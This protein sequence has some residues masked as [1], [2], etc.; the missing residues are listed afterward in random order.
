LREI[1]IE[2]LGIA[3]F[4]VLMITLI[5]IRLARGLT[6]GLN[7]LVTVA[8]N[9]EHGRPFQRQDI[10]REDEIGVLARHLY[11]M[12]D[13]IEAEKKAKIES[14]ARFR[15]LVQVV[16]IPLAYASKE[17]VIQYFN[18]RFVQVF[19]YRHEEIPTTK[20]WFDLVYPDEVYR[21]WVINNW[22]VAVQAAAASGQDIQPIEYTVTCKNGEVRI[23]EI[24]GVILGDELLATF[25][26]LTARKQAE[27]VLKE[28]EARFHAVFNNA[29][30]G[31][32]QV[33]T[34]GHFMQINQEFCKIIG[35]SKDEILSQGFTFQQITV[36]EDL[37]IDLLNINKLLQGFGSHYRVEKRYIRKNGSVVWVN[38]S[39]YLQR[40]SSSK[41]LYL[42]SAV[43]DISER[44]RAEAEIKKYHDHLEQLVEERTSQLVKAKEAAEAA[45]IAKS[46]FIATMSHE[47]RT[48]LNAILGF[49][50]FM[51]QDDTIT[52]AQKETLNIIN[53]S[54]AHLLSMINDVLD[55]SK[56][57]AGRL[58]LDV[59]ACDLIKLLQ[60]I[61]DMISTRAANSQLEFRLEIA[62]DTPQ[63]VKV[64]GGKLRQILINLL[65]N[66]IK[67]TRQGGVILRSYAQ[68]SSTATILA[69]E[70]V[71][72]GVGIPI[73]RQGE[74]FKPFVQ[75]ARTNLEVEGTGL[76]LAISKSLIE[77]MG[78]KISFTSVLGLGSTFKIELPVPI[79][80]TDELM[81]EKEPHSVKSIAVNQPAWRLLVVDDNSD[82][83]LLLVTML[84]KVGF[85]VRQAK[86]GVEAINV[87][88]Q[89]RPHLI[90]MDMQMPVM[91]GYQASAG[92]RR[93]QGGDAV[94]IIAVTDSVFKEQHNGIIN[95][96]C[97]AVL[98][99]PVQ[100]SEVFATLSQILGVKFIYQDK[101]TS[102]STLIPETTTE[103]LGKLPIEL[104]QQLRKAALSL[105]TEET[106]TVIVQIR[107]IAPDVAEGLQKLAQNYQFE[108]IIQ[109]TEATNDGYH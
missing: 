75:L 82:N 22:N 32:A 55:I 84:S 94:K 105:D 4:L 65:G 31:L 13:A 16:P 51:S 58:E 95:S 68:P 107:A 73:D 54:G 2:V 69:I 98:H 77:L 27:Q 33:A 91:D 42:I 9:A 45:N 49:S 104:Q 102:R 85:E 46:T 101:P 14:E 59:Q 56:I 74:L 7:R 29:A 97:D 80:N 71:D 53:R 99:K 60:D 61:G 72:S 106:D 83:R 30:V 18:D 108:R 44:K 10:R 37:E 41:P 81:A 5:A 6:N 35:Y 62:A 38:L 17:G 90:W 12:L 40:D 67:F 78:G 1:A 87:F 19:G 109:L 70:V 96:G 20:E 86:N 93:I 28:S 43:L 48:P 3:L 21:Q 103:M 47:L 63:Y 64:D 92:I 52:P 50:E 79:A 23:M 34:S 26:D 15:R 88:E 66:A 8:N 39:V 89:W 76:G 36:P 100:S 57:E 24:S 25:I 11:L